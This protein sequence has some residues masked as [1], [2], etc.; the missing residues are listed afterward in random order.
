MRLGFSQVSA[1]DGS[2]GA[3]KKDRPAVFQGLQSTTPTRAVAERA[4]VPGVFGRPDA[5]ADLEVRGPGGIEPRRRLDTR[6]A[7]MSTQADPSAADIILRADALMAAARRADREAREYLAGSPFRG[8]CLPAE[9]FLRLA[10]TPFQCHRR[11]EDSAVFLEA[12]GMLVEEARRICPYIYAEAGRVLQGMG[13]LPA[14]A[15]LVVAVKTA[16]GLAYAAPGGF[17]PEGVRALR[18]WAAGRTCDRTLYF[19]SPEAER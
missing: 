7:A 6:P 4:P 17:E 18:D 13:V 2:K 12:E 16:D 11:A 8:V 15:P 19:F 1:G 5:V 3:E 14:G 9:D 10:I